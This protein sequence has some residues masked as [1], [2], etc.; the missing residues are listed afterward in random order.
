MAKRRAKKQRQW[1]PELGKIITPDEMARIIAVLP[2]DA[3]QEVSARRE[4]MVMWLLIN[5]GL[6]AAEICGIRAQDTPRYLGDIRGEKFLAVKDGKGGKDRIVPV[7]EEFAAYIDRYLDEVRPGTMPQ[8]YKKND[9][10]GWLL[11]KHGKKLN[12]DQI[13][14]IVQKYRR[15]AGIEKPITPHYFRHTFATDYL[16]VSPDIYPLQRMLGHSTTNITERYVHITQFI[17]KGIGA[18]LNKRTQRVMAETV[19][20]SELY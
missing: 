10:R 12:H 13:Y 2:S 4:A 7:A 6:R 14:Y 11:F 3:T 17:G 19:Q 15:R 20:P 8:R 5:T 9:R 1:M 18:M 16:L